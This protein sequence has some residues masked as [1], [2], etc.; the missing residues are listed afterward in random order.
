MIVTCG[1]FLIIKEKT[2]TF[3]LTLKRREMSEQSNFITIINLLKTPFEDQK[4]F[5]LKQMES[6]LPQNEA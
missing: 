6:S 2:I 4:Q 1:W 5:G 3:T